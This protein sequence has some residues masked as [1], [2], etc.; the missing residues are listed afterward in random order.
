M[1]LDPRLEQWRQ[2]NPPWSSPAHAPYGLFHVPFRSA[3]LKVICCDGLETGWDHV[4]V[5]L[6][7]R[8]PNWL[9]MSFVK[10]LFW[11]ETD[12]VLQFHPKRSAYV[13]IHPHCL[14]LW[15]KFGVEHELPPEAL[16]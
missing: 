9:E 7:N 1:K 6:P 12:T 14:H 16:V 10:T 8:C 5:S 15:K 11:D 3:E 4:S 2:Q 13:D